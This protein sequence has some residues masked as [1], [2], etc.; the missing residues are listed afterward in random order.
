MLVTLVQLLQASI[1]AGLDN[2]KNSDS[3]HLRTVHASSHSKGLYRLQ[4]QTK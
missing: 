2:P 4:Y 3:L 1:L